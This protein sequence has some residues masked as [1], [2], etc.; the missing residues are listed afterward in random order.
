VF[1]DT[2]ETTLTL[3]N[4]AGAMGAIQTLGDQ[5]TKTVTFKVEGTFANDLTNGADFGLV[6]VKDSHALPVFM[7]RVNFMSE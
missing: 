2:I 7:T 1:Q 5:K 6:T 3:V 4:A